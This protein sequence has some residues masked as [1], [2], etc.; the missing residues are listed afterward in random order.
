[1]KT[2]PAVSKLLSAAAWILRLRAF[3]FVIFLKLLVTE[4]AAS[5]SDCA[6]H[7]ERY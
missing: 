7:G 2:I 1:M 3:R 4:P 5:V 6:L